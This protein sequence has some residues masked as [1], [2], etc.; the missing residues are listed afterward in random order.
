MVNSCTTYERGQLGAARGLFKTKDGARL[1]IMD[2][3]L[4]MV[5][6]NFENKSIPSDFLKPCN[7][8][9]FYLCSTLDE[10]LNVEAL[11]FL[12]EQRMGY[13]FFSPYT[14]KIK[15]SF[16]LG[17]FYVMPHMNLFI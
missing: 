8:N 4:I 17:F 11:V 15:F 5:S 1:F 6:V 14:F 10:L 16:S 9:I 2:I 3:L 13:T 12:L 7:Y